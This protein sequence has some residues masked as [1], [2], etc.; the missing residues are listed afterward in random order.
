M[1]LLASLAVLLA[2]GQGGRTLF[3]DKNGQIKVSNYTTAEGGVEENGEFSFQMEGKPALVESLLDGLSIAGPRMSGAVTPGTDKSKGFINRLDVTGNVKLTLD[4]EVRFNAVNAQLKRQGKPEMVKSASKEVMDLLTAQLNYRGGAEQGVFTV[5]VSFMIR[6]VSDDVS[7]T[8][9]KDKVI[10]TTIHEVFVVSGRS[11]VF[12]LNPGAKG[13]GRLESGEIK[14]PVSFE[15]VRTE[16]LPE[17]AKPELTKLSGTA[18]SITFDLKT[19]RTITLMGNIRIE[20][21][22]GLYRGSSE[23]DMAV[24]TLDENYKPVKIR[25]TGDPTKGTVQD[26]RGGGKR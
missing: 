21:E 24:I 12:S 19:S 25:I 7:E 6:S 20:G 9:V 2:L 13:L 15:M 1:K 14:G 18:N 22:N 4:S 8:K 16:K 10:Q 23:G 11:G 17:P 26:K 5:P 3:E